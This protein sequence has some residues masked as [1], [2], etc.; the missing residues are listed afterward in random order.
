MIPI[1]PETEAFLQEVETSTGK[2]FH[3]RREAAVLIELAEMQS[4]RQVFDDLTFYAKFVSH[5]A[6]IIKRQGAGSEDT[7]KLSLEF[8]GKLE[9]TSALVA[10]LVREAPT[11]IRQQFTERFLSLT[12]ASMESFLSFLYELSWIKNYYLDKDREVG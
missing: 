3:F 5:A 4:M 8:S 6:T 7:A 2:K 1:R 10:T 11:E 9:N 12:P